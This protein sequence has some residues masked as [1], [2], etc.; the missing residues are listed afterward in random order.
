MVKSYLFPWRAN[1]QFS[2]LVDA[3]HFFPAM[4]NAIDN[5]RHFILFEQYLVQSGEILDQFIQHLIDA[6]ERGV[7]VYLLLDDFGSSGVSR[8]D[9]QRLS[10]HG[11]DLRFYNPFSWRSLYRSLR[12]DH[13]KL[14]IV[15]N[16]VAF[17]G[18]AGISDTYAEG[19]PKVMN[20]HDVML[21]IRG[22]NVEDWIQSFMWVWNHTTDTMP[23]V[24]DY[25]RVN[26]G[27]QT[28]RVYLSR[29]L[30]RNDI[31]RSVISHIHRSSQRVWLATPYFVT[32]RKL[33]RALRRAARNGIDVRLLL[34]GPISD[35]PWISQVGRRYYQKLL[36]SGVKIFEYQPRFI[37]AKVMLCDD[38]ASIGSSNLDR[39]NQRWNL[40]ANQAVLDG[41]F[42]QQVETMFE[43]DFA[44]SQLITHED[45][46]QRSRWQ[47][48]KERYFG[49]YA[50]LLQWFNY[51]ISRRHKGPH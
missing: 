17:V 18:G 31:I 33:R 2:L 13:R 32:N 34:P 36:Q 30:L 44:Q 19:N 4:L 12:R 8:S 6:R 24:A 42:S 23:L 11:I 43:N 26:A 49:F 29:G 14:L 47:R 46:E 5:A 41:Q 20:W 3:Q 51:V 22:E 39:W 7:L 40:D 48:L 28:G 15:D 27:N 38:W 9:Q 1:N 35:H 37:H 21:Q 10:N 16:H 50:S 25:D 45:W